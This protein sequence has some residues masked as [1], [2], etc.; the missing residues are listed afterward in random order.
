MAIA[1]VAEPLPLLRVRGV[2]K[3]YAAPVLT[4]LDLDLRGGEI[5]ALMGANG[6]GKSTLSRIVCG[7]TTPDRGT[8]SLGGEPY[9]PHSRRAAQRAGVQLVMQELNL[10]PTLSVAENLFLT[11]LP[12]RFGFVAVA[13]LLARAVE[14]LTALGLNELDPRTAVSRLGIGQQQLVALAAALAHPCRVLVL[15]EPTAAL[16]SAEIELA[17]AHLRRLRAA[18]TAILYISH[19]LEEIRQI[20]DRITVLRD[21]RVVA[22][23]PA[24]DAALDEIVR[25][26]VGERAVGA[27]DQRDHS[28]GDVALRVEGLT[29][30]KR[31]RNVSFEVRKGEILGLAGL[32][33]SGRTETVRAIFGADRTHAGRV[34]R[35]P[36]PPLTIAGPKDAVRA[37]IGMIPEDRKEQALL[38]SQPVRMNMTLAVLPAFVR[39]R[40]WIDD[41]RELRAANELRL[42]LDV[43]SHSLNQ[44]AGELSGGN[45]QKVVI[46]RWLLRECDVLLFDEPTRGIDVAAKI[47]VYRVLN[48]LAARGKALVVVS[49]ELAELMALCDRIAVMSAGRL[50]TTFARG[51]W[52]EDAIVAAA[53]SEYAGRGD[54]ARRGRVD[55]C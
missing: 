17:F 26:M 3:R 25:L 27:L 14:A 12:G 45:Q 38:L 7:L 44:R 37:G 4:D 15:D 39:R 29:R 54:T 50:V 2:E 34:S 48:E 23:Q 42:R 49:S 13:A 28:P 33:G 35:G 43:R 46:A 22:T 47:A 16:T 6:A 11:D 24:A 41:A 36:G 53:F 55:S 1:N 21:G 40:W 51:E 9:Q 30:G 19:R 10:V 18:G 8:M 20:S 31:L 52:S 32:V 5:H